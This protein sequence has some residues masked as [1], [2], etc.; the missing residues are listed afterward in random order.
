MAIVGSNIIEIKLPHPERASTLLLLLQNAL[1]IVLAGA[2]GGYAVLQNQSK[3]KLQ[4]DLGGKLKS[5][6]QAVQGLER[7]V[8]FLS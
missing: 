2:L 8:G 6:Q 1:G 5:Q 4:E 7:E 3:E